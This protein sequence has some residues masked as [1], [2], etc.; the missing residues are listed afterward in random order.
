MPGLDDPPNPT[1]RL[2]SSPKTSAAALTGRMLRLSWRYRRQCLAAVAL[3]ALLVVF[4]VGG[5]GL[6]GLG[7]D[8]IRHEVDRTSSPP[9]WLFDIQPPSE[10]PPIAVVATIAASVLA[11]AVCGAMLK[12]V[13]AVAGAALSQRV[14]IQLRSDVYDKLQRLSFRFFDANM[15]SSLINR[16]SG[17]A[18]AVRT[19]VDGVIIKVLV[20]LLSLAVYVAYMLSVHATLTAVC[21]LTLPLLFCGAVGFSRIVQPAYRRSSE[22]VDDLI[23]TLVENIQGIHVVKGFARE[24]QQIAKFR[25]ANRRVHDQ[26][27]S[28]F[29]KI[30]V[31]QPVM[32]LL[33]QL[34]ML[35][36]I[37]YG[38]YLVVQGELQLG[39]GMFVFANLLHEFANQV[40][41]ITNIANTI[42]SSLT[43][44]Q[45]VF[46]VLDAPVEIHSPPNAVRLP[47][48][49]G[50]VRFENVAFAYDGERAD[51]DAVLH[52]VSFEI[53]AGECLGIVGETGAGKST[54]LALLARF[55]DVSA[56]MISVDGID[57]R[58]LDV[59]DLRHNIGIVFQESFL[60]SNT[61]AANIAFGHPEATDEE[62]SRAARISAADEFIREMPDGYETVV[63]EYGS[64]LSGGQRQRLAVARALLLDPPILVLDD[65]TASVDPETEHAIREAIQGAMRGRTTLV[66]SGRIGTLRHADWIIVLDKG[67]IV[68]QGTPADLLHRD[69]PYRRMAQLQF[70]DQPDQPEP[71]AAAG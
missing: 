63:G 14:L 3:N 47:R 65:A 12:Y 67:R 32:G 56:G 21:L 48:A 54:L 71:L 44:A 26:K 34:N 29:R 28:I 49:K 46:E 52:D 38:G 42:Q 33:T 55:Y 15:S 40:G 13:T 25:D 37:G 41:Q 2:K 60:F 51:G 1:S 11:L 6:T 36:L 58:R 24:K 30:S 7:I 61:I 59:D 8:Y 35:V 39:A 66:V 4:N 45:R 20:V 62:I 17:D 9:K 22:L 10:W 50:G 23:M 19:F 31:Y 16:A 5:L 64:N 43:G 27:R 68:Q 57:V 53:A 18:Q 69:G 70:A